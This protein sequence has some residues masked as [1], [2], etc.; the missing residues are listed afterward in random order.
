MTLIAGS[1]LMTCRELT[2]MNSLLASKTEIHLMMHW[3][4]TTEMISFVNAEAE[5]QV[6]KRTK[7]RIRSRSPCYADR[8]LGNDAIVGP[9]YPQEL[10]AQCVD[11]L[12]FG[13]ENVTE[14]ENVIENESVIESGSV[15]ERKCHGFDFDS[16]I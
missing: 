6:A 7:Q 5:V 12:H 16:M 13:Y 4:Q 14:S 15:I 3:G 11:N 10:F 1:N 9:K 2:W 8:E